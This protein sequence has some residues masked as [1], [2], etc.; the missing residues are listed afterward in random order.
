MP[1]RPGDG[2]SS[3]SARYNP[4]TNRLQMHT[5]QTVR[6]ATADDLPSIRA[7]MMRDPKQPRIDDHFFAPDPRRHLLVLDD[8]HGALVA[9]ALLTIVKG[10]GHLLM[11]VVSAEADET[12]A[13]HDRMFG[14][15]EAMCD[16]YGASTLDV[17]ARQAA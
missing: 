2:R 5:T 10:S 12:H 3:R 1:G 14:V 16:A 8:E 13:L 6:Y 4:C 17:P 9:A 7:L 15:V 11:L